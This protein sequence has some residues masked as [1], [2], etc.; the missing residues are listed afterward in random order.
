M[1]KAF[2]NSSSKR[3]LLSLI[4]KTRLIS[5][6]N[7]TI[8]ITYS[9]ALPARIVDFLYRYVPANGST[10]PHLTYRLLPA[11]IP[12]R[13]RL[14]QGEVFIY[15]DSPELV[16]ELLL[17]ESCYHLAAQSQ[18][19]LLFHA[20]GLAKAGAG[21]LLPGQTGAGKSTLTTWLLTQ[22][23]DYLTDELIFIPWGTHMMQPLTRPLNLKRSARTV[24]YPL[25]DFATQSAN[26]LSSPRVDLI[27][28]TLFNP[29]VPL[30][31]AS[32][33][34]IIFPHYQPDSDFTLR[35]LSRAQAGLELMR[36]LINARNL[37]GQGFS[38]VTRLVKAIPAYKLSYT[39]FEQIGD[40]ITALLS[41]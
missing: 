26:I 7:N 14:Y 18:S 17:G 37:A 32:L 40:Q 30:R 34:L 3:E 4:E 41:L 29:A 1:L 23:F 2:Y 5:F 20:A 8:A 36:C 9:G 15:E 33:S 28:P 39:N 38:E 19:G 22:N 31:Q 6:A 13:V 11:D 21:L 35:P 16:A 25:F 10:P 27:P 12:N 24:L